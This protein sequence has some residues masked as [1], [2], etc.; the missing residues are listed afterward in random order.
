MA[1]ACF[2]QNQAV[3]RKA[4]P[5]KRRQ[6]SVDAY[7]RLIRLAVAGKRMEDAAALGERAMQLDPMEFPGI[8]YYDAVANYELKHADVAEKAVRRAIEIDKARE[9]PAAE[10]LL[11]KVLADKGDSRG[12]MDHFTKYVQ[13]APKAGDVPPSASAWR[14]WSAARRNRHPPIHWLG[15]R[16]VWPRTASR[17]QSRRPIRPRRS[18]RRTTRGGCRTWPRRQIGEAATQ[19]GHPEGIARRN[20][21]AGVQAHGRRRRSRITAHSKMVR[22]PPTDIAQTMDA[23]ASRAARIPI[24]QRAVAAARSA[25]WPA[26]PSGIVVPSGCAVLYRRAQGACTSRTIRLTAEF[27]HF[28]PPGTARPK[29]AAT[30]LAGR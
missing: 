22:P 25:L 29:I 15:S 3:S 7:L 10:A 11:G 30:R 23:G 26:N 8:Y 5:R 4:R 28:A 19:P 16:P 13:L 17:R 12:A 21:A 27:G 18:R 24:R 9:Y 14:S 1:G 2:A 6:P 20:C